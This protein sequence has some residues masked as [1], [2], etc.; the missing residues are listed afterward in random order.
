MI[1]Y[2]IEVLLNWTSSDCTYEISELW[3]VTDPTNV[4]PGSGSRGWLFTDRFFL[5]VLFLTRDLELHID[6]LKTL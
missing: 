6:G 5:Y 2:S 3:L 1:Y 4:S